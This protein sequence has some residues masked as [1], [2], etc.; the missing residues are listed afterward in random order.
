MTRLILSEFSIK[1]D[2]KLRE[3]NSDYDAKRTE[4]F[5]LGLPDVVFVPSGT[6]EAWLDS[7]PLRKWLK[8]LVGARGFEPPTP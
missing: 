5:V 8:F 3:L 6:F 2:C 1:L 7:K 4:D